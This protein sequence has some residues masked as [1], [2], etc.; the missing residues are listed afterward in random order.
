MTSV[1]DRDGHIESFDNINFELLP[2]VSPATPVLIDSLRKLKR[3]NQ[4]SNGNP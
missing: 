2:G 3:F 4:Q 1:I